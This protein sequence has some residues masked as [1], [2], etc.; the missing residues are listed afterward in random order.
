MIF[1]NALPQECFGPLDRNIGFGQ[2]GDWVWKYMFHLVL[3][4]RKFALSKKE[5]HVRV[6]T[7]ILY[8]TID[9]IDKR[10][11]LQSARIPPFQN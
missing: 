8:F 10:T 7:L 9:Y 11:S 5:T 1:G 6:Q 2:R 3:F 4:Y